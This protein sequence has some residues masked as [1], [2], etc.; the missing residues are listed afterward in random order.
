[1]PNTGT[2]DLGMERSCFWQAGYGLADLRNSRVLFGAVRKLAAFAIGASSLLKLLADAMEGLSL[3]HIALHRLTIL[4]LV[5]LHS[6]LRP[7]PEDDGD[8]PQLAVLL[9]RQGVDAMLPVDV[10]APPE[11]EGHAVQL[12]EVGQS[13]VLHVPEGE[14]TLAA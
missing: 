6:Q 3:R 5:L 8:P 4:W 2:G 1:M 14:L 7:T 12:G 9:R 13:A 10:D 11:G